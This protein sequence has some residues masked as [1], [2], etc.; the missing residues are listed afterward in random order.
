M[1]APC[2]YE[3]VGLEEGGSVETIILSGIC[4]T[5]LREITNDD[6]PVGAGFAPHWQHH[7]WFSSIA[8]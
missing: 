8:S 1:E 7:S 2:F 3:V 4:S 5:K 6:L